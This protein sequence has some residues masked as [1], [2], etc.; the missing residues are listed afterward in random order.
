MSTME[1]SNVPTNDDKPMTTGEDATATPPTKQ[2]KLIKAGLLSAL[3]LV[4]VYV[5]LD[6]T[7]SQT[8]YSSHRR[9]TAM[10]AH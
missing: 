2:Q 9:T 6:Y 7:V 3:A 10:P 4:I 5:I 8:I 1:L